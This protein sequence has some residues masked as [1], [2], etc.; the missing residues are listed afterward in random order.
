QEV[1]TPR[2]EVLADYLVSI[3]ISR[4]APS[5]SIPSSQEQEHSPIMSQG[6]VDPTLFT[7]H[8]GND[9]LLSKN[10]SEIVKKY[11]LN[12]ID[13]VDTPMIENKKLDED[14]HGKPVDATLYHR[15]IGS[16]MYLTASRPDVNYVVCLCARIMSF[17]TAQQTKL[18]LE[19]VPKE[20][21]L[22]I[23]KCNGRI[24]RGLT[25]REPLFQVVLDA[26]ALT[27]CYPAFLITADVPEVYMHQCINLG[28]LLLLLSI[29]FYPER[30]AVLTSFVSPELKS[31]GMYGAILPECLTSSS[32]KESKAY[33]TYLDYATGAVPP[34]LATKFKKTSPSNKESNLVPIN[35]GPITKGKRVKRSVKKSSTKPATGIVIIKPPVKNKSKRKEKVDVTHEKGIELLF[36]VAL[37]KE[38]Q[39]KEVRKMSLRG[40]QKIH[41]SGSG[42]VAEKPPKVDNITTS[43][44]SEGTGDKPGVLDVTKYKSTE[45]ESESWGNDK[46]DN[47]DDNDSENKGNE[48]KSDDDK[49]PFDSEKYSDSEQDTD[50]S[51]SYSKSDQQEYE[52]DVKDDDEDDDDDDD[53][54]EGDEDRGIDDTTNQFSDDDQDKKADVEMTDA[55]QDK[56]E[57]PFAGSNQEFKKRKTSKDSK[58]TTSPKNKDSTSRTSKGTKSQPKSTGKTIYSE[59]PKFEVGDTNTPQGHEGNLGN[60]DVEPR[61]ESASR[62]DWFTKPSRPQ[63]PTDLD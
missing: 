1:A 45:S 22:D 27:P 18:D 37:T 2:A 9:L 32:M 17:I 15:M 43:V 48:N 29:K 46:D 56:D 30:P 23:S 38:A 57:G 60:D 63:E 47:N 49:T 31:F 11:G 35:K 20:N 42:T 62:R 40:F 5:T 44:T 51:E 58:L 10:A 25:P 3:C 13:P 24:T 52:E 14:I 61:K 6:A 55:Q 16:L 53:K 28:E 36:E 59:E 33:K 19:L 12:S 4:D 26:I 39:M 7:W 54:F 8:A 34:K 41:P 50:R 21:R